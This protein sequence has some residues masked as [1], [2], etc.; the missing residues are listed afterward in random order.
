MF[1]VECNEYIVILQKKTNKKN[2]SLTN[3]DHIS[4]GKVHGDQINIFFHSFF[5]NCFILVKDTVDPEQTRMSEVDDFVLVNLSFL[6]VLSLITLLLLCVNALV[7]LQ[8]S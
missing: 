4:A 5:S 1:I 3:I 6:S 8:T 2:I 7:C